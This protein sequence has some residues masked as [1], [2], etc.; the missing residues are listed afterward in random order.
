MKIRRMKCDVLVV[1]AGISGIAAAAAA[2]RKNVAVLLL[3]KNKFPG[4]VAAVAMHNSIC[5]ADSA[6]HGIPK[7]IMS[8]LSPGLKIVRR[9]KVFL[10]P[11]HNK[12]LIPV[13]RQFIEK[14]RI[15]SLYGVRAVSVNKKEGFITVVTAKS[16]QG[17]ILISPKVVIDA[18]GDGDI[19]RFSSSGLREIPLNKRQLAGFSFEIKGLKVKDDILQI[20]VAYYLNRGAYQKRFPMIFRF[21]SFSYGDSNSSGFI[22][23]NH[24][25]KKNNYSSFD[26]KRYCDKVH[27]YLSEKL[28]EFR[29]SF[30]DR[31]SHS[32]SSRDGTRLMGEYV[33]KKDDLLN[34]KKFYDCASSGSWPIEFW[35]KEK[36]QVLI[37]P[38]GKG[39]YDI[40]LRSLKSNKLNNLFA[41][42]KCISADP[43]ALS[44][45]RVMGICMSLGE[46]AGIA[47]SKL[48][49]SF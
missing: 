23:L 1:G 20:K 9:G 13:L 3:E 6:L 17:N 42:G 25:F 26:L 41:I 16:C 48:C 15:K 34:N 45:A 12:R 2:A 30:I 8:K 10:L 47:A 39:H 40:P 4:G 7:E 44:S 37:Y 29:G 11:F 28:P 43:F 31:F 27:S 35:S 46:S 33:L 22:R 19:V 14:S 18:S 32:V 36:G 5:G 24:I 21:G 38:E 49:A